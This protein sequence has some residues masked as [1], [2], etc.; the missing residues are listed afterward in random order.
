[1]TF[2]EQ[3]ETFMNQINTRKR[4]PARHATLDTYRSLLNKWILPALGRLPL[5]D[6]QN[7][8]VKPLV[9]ALSRAEMSAQ[10]IT[11]VISLVKAVVKSATDGN[12]NELYPR[13]WNNDF[14]DIPTVNHAD[15][16]APTPTP[17]AVQ[18]AV[19]GS[20][21]QIKALIALLAGTGLRIGEA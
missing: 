5:A 8:T 3:A 10:T 4:N 1:M 14:L 2:T 17:K 15:Q 18:K 7:G 20:S 11:S 12:G 19:D 16:K 13:T 21:G 6:V 9:D